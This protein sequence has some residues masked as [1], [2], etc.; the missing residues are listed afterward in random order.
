MQASRRDVMWAVA[1]SALVAAAGTWPLGAVM[2]A[3]GDPFAGVDPEM[4]DDLRLV[5]DMIVSAENLA[6]FRARPPAV[7]AHPVPEPVIAKAPLEVRMIPGLPGQPPVRTLI[8]DGAPGRKARGALIWIHG[9][10][11]V[12]GSAG[13][14]A[15]LRVAAQ[16]Q[17]WLIVSPEYR[18]AP[19]ARFPASLADNYAALKW[20]HDNADT[21]GVDRRRIAVGGSSAGGG[22][23]AMLAIAAR[24]RGEIPVA[25]QVLIY[26]M[27]DDRT[28]SSRP[29]RPGTGQFIWTPQANRFGWASLLGQAPGGAGAP[30]GAVPA[31]VASVKGL[32][33]AF[34]GVGTLDLFYDE[35]IAY[36][37]ALTL[38]GIGVDLAVVPA[39][40]HAFDGVA[41]AARASRAFTERWLRDLSMALAA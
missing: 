34:I 13:I 38:A 29:A 15:A 3:A 25:F 36:A 5:K 11:Y 22:H 35:D 24:D 33:P 26:P 4:I 31:R 2:P 20:V 18:L 17:G 39:A 27:L 14:G 28:A 37:E 9:G 21:L 6:A 7:K 10:G 16:E 23:S 40:F 1:A 19:E 32:P 30:A 12:A 8:F 41:P